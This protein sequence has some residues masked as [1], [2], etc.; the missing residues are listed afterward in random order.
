MHNA[1]D[2]DRL[3]L[4]TSCII[5][6]DQEL[7]QP[8]PIEV[9]SHDGRAHNVTMAPGDMVLYESH[10]VLHGRPFPMKG[11]MYAN[12]FVHF[13][14]V[15]HDE[16]LRAHGSNVG[17]YRRNIRKSSDNMLNNGEGEGGVL[18]VPLELDPLAKFG[19][20]KLHDIDADHDLIASHRRKRLT[21]AN[22]EAARK[23]LGSGHSIQPSEHDFKQYEPPRL[24]KE[25]SDVLKRKDL[26]DLA[27]MDG[28][29]DGGTRGILHQVAQIGD[30]QTLMKLLKDKST[31]DLEMLVNSKD[32]NG[33]QP[34]HEAVRGGHLQVVKYLVEVCGADISATT[35]KGGT[36]LWWARQTLNS[37]HPVIA[38]LT[39]IGA[40]NVS[41]GE[42]S[43]GK[44]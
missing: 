14:P 11:D 35:E 30:L 6:V 3:P 4:V 38:F 18:K 28:G 42:D 5:N 16:I 33:W 41:V 21:K 37:E 26:Q 13:K 7:E 24:K 10:T 9:Y 8:W 40:P 12:I 15:H 25:V 32:S 1:V 39:S 19:G 44:V 23:A 29:E 34:I 36:A 31:S 27:S 20:P 22:A 17:Q 2:V 43:T